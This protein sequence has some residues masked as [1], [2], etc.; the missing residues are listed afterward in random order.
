MPG[1]PGAQNGKG[2][3]SDPNYASRLLARSEC[4]LGA[5]KYSYAIVSHPVY[6]SLDED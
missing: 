1:G 3:Q 5:Q 4:L 2:A 6:V